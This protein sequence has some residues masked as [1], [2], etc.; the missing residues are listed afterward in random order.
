MEIEKK[1]SWEKNIAKLFTVWDGDDDDND[2]DDDDDKFPEN[3]DK[4]FWT[5]MLF[6]IFNLKSKERKA[7][8][9]VN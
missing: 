9:L 5:E 8:D 3:S 1:N 4:R 7:I 2:D 6:M